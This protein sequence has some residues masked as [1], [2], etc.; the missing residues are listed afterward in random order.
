M[1]IGDFV[2]SFDFPDIEDHY[3]EGVLVDIV[4]DGFDCP[5][6]QIAVLCRVRAGDVDFVNT[7]S[8]VFPPVNG[9]KTM[10]GR[11][12]D[13]VQKLEPHRKGQR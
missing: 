9:T 1:K 3:V 4:D 6:Y 10:L 13:G 5:R 2:R 12:T 8:F 7:P 11:V